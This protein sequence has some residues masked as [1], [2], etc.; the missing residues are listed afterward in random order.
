MS[1][2]RFIKP[3]NV[4]GVAKSSGLTIIPQTRKPNL[5]HDDVISCIAGIAIGPRDL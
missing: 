5:V 2:D 4:S 3:D 1:L